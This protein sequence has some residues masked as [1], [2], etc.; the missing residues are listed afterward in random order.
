MRRFRTKLLWV[1]MVAVIVAA[2][3]ASAPAQA[4]PYTGCLK[5]RGRLRLLIRDFQPVK[6]CKQSEVQIS[7]AAFDVVAALIDTTAALIE[8]DN[9]VDDRIK[10][11]EAIAADFEANS[12]AILGDIVTKSDDLLA[13]FTAGAE[14]FLTNVGIASE[15]ALAQVLDKIEGKVFLDENNTAVGLDTLT[16]AGVIGNSAFGTNALRNLADASGNTAVGTDALMNTTGGGEGNFNTA[17]GWHA[18]N[19][20]QGSRNTALGSGAGSLLREGSDNIYINHDG[21]NSESNTI[22]IGNGQTRAF[23]AGIADVNVDGVAVVVDGNGQLGIPISSRRYKQDIEPL[24]EL[25]QDLMRLRPVA[26]RYKAPDANG[27]QPLQYGLI[28]EEVAQVYPDLVAYSKDGRAQTVKY[29]KLN[30]MLLNELQKQQKRVR[31]QEDLIAKLVTRL[32]RVEAK[33]AN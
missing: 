2:I 33:L 30:S 11:V 3:P 18:F 14:T 20:M 5:A 12:T 21:E 15:A 16:G 25:S 27:K 28:A 29:H 1:L 32:A 19:D 23:V 10:A 9:S 13:D 22:R 4:I 17:I 6:R 31:R 24:G 26:Y 8:R 7:L